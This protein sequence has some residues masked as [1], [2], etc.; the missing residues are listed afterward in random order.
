MTRLR[1]RATTDMTTPSAFAVVTGG[2]TA[3]H[4]LPA[5][6][7]LD[8]LVARGHDRS[9]LQYVGAQRGVET[10]LV[11]PS[12]V[13][14]TFLDVIGLQ[15]R[16][17]RANLGFGPRLIRAV[18]AAG[19]LLDERRP[20]VVVSVGGYASLP[21]VLAARRRHIPVVVVSYDRRPGRSSQISARIATACAVAFEDSPLP[22]A[23]HTGAPVRREILAVNRGTDRDEARRRRGWRWDAFV[24]AVV[25][26]SQGSGALNQAA[27][28]LVERFGGD[29]SMVL[30]HVAGARFL[31]E[32]TTPHPHPE[33]MLYSVVGFDED[34]A[35]LYAGCDLIVA[36]GGASTVIEVA[37]TGT[38]AVLV[39]WSGAAE[40]HQHANVAW[41]ADQQAAV[42][43]EDRELDALGDVIAA[44]QKNRSE[45]VAMGERAYAAGEIH[46]RG[47]VVSLIEEVAQR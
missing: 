17:T 31:D 29:A 15:R 21:A 37:V 44:R 28:A 8:G 3:G 42:M 22:R 1:S 2:G 7:L 45:L 23:R 32:M 47:D 39:P 13:P 43:L 11:P 19:R 30:H 33:A 40:A 26:G 25:G 36:R 12:G 38:P 18:R 4:V 35:S 34:M 20:R 16:L 9:S 41:L 14:A 6:A 46:R 10:D 27:L 24:V 5:L